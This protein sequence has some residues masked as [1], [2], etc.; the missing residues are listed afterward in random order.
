MNMNLRFQNLIPAA[1]GLALVLAAPQIVP[2]ARAESA[3]AALLQGAVPSLAPIVERVSP[4]VV[5][6]SVKVKAKGEPAAAR[7]QIPEEFR[8]FFEGPGAGRGGDDDDDQQPAR[9]RQRD[10]GAMGSGV[11][12]DAKKGYI[13]TNHHVVEDASEITVTL[14]DRRELTAKMIGTDKGT[15]VALLQVEAKDLVQLPIGDSST[16]KVGDYVLAVGNPFGLGQTVTSGIVSAL[17]RNSLNIEGFE[18][19]IQT[20]A[21]IN[22][23]NS[24]GALINLKGELIG[25]NTAII[26]PSGGNVGIG[27]A[28]PTNMSEQVVAQL[29]KYGEVKRGRLG[30]Q[31]Q[32]LT[33]ELA[34][35]LGLSQAV[36]AVIGKIEK[37]SP[38]DHAG[39][40][41][42]DVVIA[43][44]DKALASSGD[45]RVRIGLMPLGTQA[46][47]T[48]L[49]DGSKKNMD[50]TIGKLPTEQ[51][52][53]ASVSE[54]QSL[55]GASFS[56]VT[57]ADAK[58][59][60]GVRIT[61][62][63]RNSPAY[64]IG[65]RANDVI[66]SV[67]RTPVKN[68]EDFDNALK[69]SKRQAALFIKRGEEDLLV[70]V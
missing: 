6:I 46:H 39:L 10:R 26:G 17:G 51:K 20:D 40:K 14:K 5:N 15:D 1:A 16:L 23:G 11:I 64:Q 32:D 25:I 61:D 27:F 62:V 58:G 55:E 37:D 36:G 43:V 65:L 4:A 18:D 68:M 69:E 42:G 50:V 63:E 22:P 38:A 35:N 57:L 67:N 31:I 49:R 2:H 3:S 8:R 30:V 45:L 7:G 66:T 13:I 47:L 21:S 59:G 70:I 33:P 28:I 9:P 12:I 44:N 24:G 41:T 60:K 19:F 54:R 34:K 48:V 56:T 53:A 29:A 52:V